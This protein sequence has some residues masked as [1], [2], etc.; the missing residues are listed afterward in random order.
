MCEPILVGAGL[1]ATGNVLQAGAAAEQAE[2]ENRANFYNAALAERNATLANL[3]AEWSLK[4]GKANAALTRRDVKQ[5]VGSQRA[6]YGASGAVVDSGSAAD[7]V[8]DTQALGE[9]DALTIERNAARQAWAKQEEG[10]SYQL[11]ADMYRAG[12]KDPTDVFGSTLLAGLANTGGQFLVS[13]GYDK[14]SNAYSGG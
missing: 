12:Y 10:K 2:A 8:V 11:Q 7:V 5:V 4:V 9:M 1:M 14:F 13:G 3:D 6:S